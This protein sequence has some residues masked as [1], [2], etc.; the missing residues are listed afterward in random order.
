MHAREEH[1]WLKIENL[2]E[3]EVFLLGFER[4]MLNL[5]IVQIR[6]SVLLFLKFLEFVYMIILIIF[7]D[8]TGVCDGWKGKSS[9]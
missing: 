9:R 8:L 1:K 4:G 2:N 5:S 6:H 3:N 7:L